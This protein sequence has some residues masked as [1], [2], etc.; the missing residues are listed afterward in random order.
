MNKEELMNEEL[1]AVEE[2]TDFEPVESTEGEVKTEEPNW[3]SFLIG[4]R[5]D[6]VYDVKTNVDPCMVTDYTEAHAGITMN[7]VVTLLKSNGI[8]AVESFFKMSEILALNSVRLMG[9]NLEAIGISEEEYAELRNFF[10]IDRIEELLQ[11]RKEEMI[12]TE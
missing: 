9:Q 2:V 5:G 7:I 3:M 8:G 10:N 1:C 6:S 11:Q 4:V 12:K